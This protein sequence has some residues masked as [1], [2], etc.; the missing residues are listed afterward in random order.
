MRLY[1]ISIVLF[2]LVFAVLALPLIT[3][4]FTNIANVFAIVPIPQARTETD[5]GK[6]VLKSMSD[7]IFTLLTNPLALTIL[8]A[9]SLVLYAAEQ[10]VARQQQQQ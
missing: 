9:I 3:A 2:V 1:P 8:V 10:A 4:L 5:L 7:W 6:G